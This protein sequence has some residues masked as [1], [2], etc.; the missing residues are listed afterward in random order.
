VPQTKPTPKPINRPNQTEQSRLIEASSFLQAAAIAGYDG[1]APGLRLDRC[2][3]EHFGD[4]RRHDENVGEV[5]NRGQ[6]AF[7]DGAKVDPADS[8]DALDP[9]IRIGLRAELA[10]GTSN[11]ELKIASPFVQRLYGFKQNIAPF[12]IANASDVKHHAPIESDF[13]ALAGGGGRVRLELLSIFTLLVGKSQNLLDSRR[14][15]CEHGKRR[16]NCLSTLS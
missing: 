1:L 15:N 6:S 5:V 2:H 10:D 3:S 8:L 4:A 13:T 14:Q 7:L 16:S 9:A 11:H 12:L